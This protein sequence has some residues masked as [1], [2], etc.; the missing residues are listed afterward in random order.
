MDSTDRDGRDRRPATRDELMDHFSA[1]LDGVLSDERPPEGLPAELLAELTSSGH[2]AAEA[3]EPDLYRLWSATTSLI[4][5]VKLQGRAF[6][7][8][9][10]SLQSVEGLGA[11]LDS[12]LAAQRQTLDTIAE[13]AADGQK[14]SRQDLVRRAQRQVRLDTL[15]TLMDVR[16]RLLR[17]L[18]TSQA[19]LA[20][21]RRTSASSWLMRLCGSA[22]DD[23][24][25]ATEAVREGNALALAHV[26]QLL[27]GDGVSEIECVG[28]PFDPGCMRAVA[29]EPR[30]DRETGEVM[31]VL[32]RGYRRKDEVLRYAE[33]R[34]TGR[35]GQ[36]DGDV[37]PS[38]LLGES[39]GS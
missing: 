16:D 5:E 36:D 19:H 28:R 21:A 35:P 11:A 31:E 29:I 14:T 33:V 30:A 27:A 10:D 17:G 38:G 26:D 2:E 9:G 8:L 23:L 6:D 37:Q 32:R 15:E 18:A 34:V 1:W 4:Q 25:A 39:G 12:A 7:R 20:R 13:R 22:F 24:L 3:A